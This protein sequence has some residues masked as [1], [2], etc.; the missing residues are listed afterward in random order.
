MICI[1]NLFFGRIPNKINNI[2]SIS[3]DY[4]FT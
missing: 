4:Y 2:L 1:S 3:K